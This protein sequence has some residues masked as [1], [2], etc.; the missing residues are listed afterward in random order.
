MRIGV[1]L[2]PVPDWGAV[3]EG[4][5]AA[6]ELGF[7]SIGLWDH[8][9]SA[10]PEWA[11]VAGWSAHAAL[12]Q[13][14]KRTKITPA[15]LNGLHYELG[16]LAKESSM[17]ALLSEGRFELAIGAG[18]WPS[19]HAAWGL[20]FPPAGERVERLRESIDLLRQL[21]SG[22]AVTH[23]G[24]YNKLDQASCTPVPSTPPRV[25]IGA[26]SSKALAHSAV[27]YADEINVYDGDGLIGYARGAIDSS[28]RD[29]GLSTYLSW[30]WDKWP[31]DAVER[32]GA[33]ETAGVDRVLINIGSFEMPARLKQ[34]EALIRVD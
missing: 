1:V 6:D 28:G 27:E 3:K 19:S 14:T 23:E 25:V 26:G 21:W 5:I 13:A 7:D 31:A 15:V 30:E 2:S 20:P 34:L 22:A 10:R 9:H 17:L 32:I 18:D 12:A 4:G 29:V 16:V 11:Y 33:F 24:Q 8:Y